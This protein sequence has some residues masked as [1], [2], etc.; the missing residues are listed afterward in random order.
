MRIVFSYALCKIMQKF[1]K[2]YKLLHSIRAIR[3]WFIFLNSGN[4][5]EFETIVQ[6]WDAVDGAFISS[7]VQ[8]RL[9]KYLEESVSKGYKYV[10][11]V[12]F[13]DYES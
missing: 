8:M 9:H 4:L 13:V 10:Y 5:V 3:H 2:L 7:R 6:T 12:W 11:V 1:L